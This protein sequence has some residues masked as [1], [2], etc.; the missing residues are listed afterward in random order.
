MNFMRTAVLLAA[1][2]ALFLVVGALLGGRTGMLMALV[3]AIG[4][5]IFAWWNSDRMAL[6]AN[7]AQEVDERQAPELFSLVR[8]LAGRAQIPMPRVY[9]IESEQ[10]NA[11]ATGRDPQHAAVAVHTGLIRMLSREELA[12]VLAHELAHIKNRDTLTMTISA[13]LAGAILSIAHWG[14][15]FGGGRRNGPGVIGTL[16][17]AFLAPMA[18]GIVQMAVSRSREYV[19]DAAGGEIC[20]NPRWLARALA[21]ISAGA[22][23]IPNERAE[24]NPA[25]AHL[26]IV[27]PLSGRG[28]DNLF[29]THPNVENR[30]AALEELAQRMNIAPE[31][32]VGVGAWSPFRDDFAQPTTPAGSAWGRARPHDGGF[33][34]GGGLSPWRRGGDRGTGGESRGRRG[35][36]G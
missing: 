31:A 10:P 4:T 8:E 25:M 21:K 35:P 26:F 3:F 12:G 14:M 33:L 20:G 24:A 17:L 1:M 15:F 18:A 5:N 13:T 11:F 23:A 36:W 22:Q 9:V 19:A 34:S 28:V 32:G 29:S 27:N 30:I 2:T 16:A 7:D 6:A